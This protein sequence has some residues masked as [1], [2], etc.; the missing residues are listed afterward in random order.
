VRRFVQTDRPNRAE[1]DD[2]CAGRHQHIE[3]RMMS[4]L[5]LRFSLV[6]GFAVFSDLAVS[7]ADQKRISPDSLALYAREPD[8]LWNRLHV[9]LLV[10]TGPDGKDYGN[11]RLEPLLWKDSTYLL[12][13]QTGDRALAILNEFDRDNAER[14]IEDPLR[15]A[16]LQRD[17]WLVSNCVSGTADSAARQQF[18]QALDKVIYRVALTREQI[19][20]LPDNYL[21]TVASLK[22]DSRFD[23]NRPEQA[24]L[25]DNLFDEAGPWVCVSPV[26]GPSAPLHL[27]D[28]GTNPFGNSVFF[29]FL[30]LPGGKE[31]GLEFLRKLAALDKLLVPNTD[32][33]TNRITSLLPHPDFPV[34]P[35][36]T[37]VALVRR[38]LLI[39]TDR[40]IVAS[41]LTESIQIRVVTTDMPK[42]NKE[43]LSQ[44]SLRRPPDGWQAAFEFQLRR[45]DLFEGETGLRDVSSEQDFKTGFNSHP[46]DEFDKAT[47]SGQFPARSMPFKSN[48]AS[49]TGCHNFPGA[50]SFNSIPGFS[51]GMLGPINEAW[52]KKRP[53]STTVVEV[54]KKAIEWRTGRSSWTALIKRLP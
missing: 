52:R 41:R 34:W 46:R 15:R 25:P 10:R 38:A 49:C 26:T 7:G 32:E 35:K 6:V 37:E 27:D 51:F 33:T 1:F 17:L 18:N 14:L 44:I 54:E 3:K 30:K 42:L 31:Q 28:R 16:V 39:D 53:I 12:E 19:A 48:R 40:Q 4:T 2:A 24:Y 36:G 29:V 43:V 13:G 5:V 50:Y 21:R 9:A 8:H 11:D 22:Y 45:I 20:N 47:R 23:P